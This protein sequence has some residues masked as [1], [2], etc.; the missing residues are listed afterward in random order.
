[1]LTEEEEEEIDV[2]INKYRC[3]ERFEASAG[4]EHTGTESGANPDT[5]GLC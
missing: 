1:M 4:N 2:E 3:E 5:S